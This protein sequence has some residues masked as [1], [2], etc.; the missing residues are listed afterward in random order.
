VGVTARKPSTS[1]E[2]NG[3]GLF[4]R[5]STG[6]VREIG[7]SSAF[8]VNAGAQSIG[9]A[10]AFFGLLLLLFPGVN[11]LLM[12]VIGGLLIAPLAWVYSQLAVTM[13]RSGGDYVFLSRVFHPVAGVTAGTLHLFIWWS[14]L[15]ALGAFWA[16]AF[17]PFTFGTLATVFHAPSL[18]SLASDVATRNGTFVATTTILVAAALVTLG[19]TKLAARV[20][21]W[22]VLA[23]VISIVLVLV[24]LFIHSAGD[25]Q[26]A[27]DHASGAIGT[28][29]R[30]VAEARAHGWGPGHTVSATL[31]ALPY[32]FLI[33][34]GYWYTA[35]VAGEVRRPG[36][37]QIV[38]T[39][40]T[41]AASVLLLALAWVGVE[42]AAGARF[43]EAA[44][45]LAG[46]APAVYAK[47]TP[48]G[49]SPHG[50]AVL[51]ADPVTRLVIA[52]GFLGW[53]LPVPI[54]FLMGMSRTLFALS[55]DR[56]LPRSVASVTSRRH[57]PAVALL[58][59]VV[60]SEAFLAL[61]VYEQGFAQAFRNANLLAL[62]LSTVACLAVI[63]LPFRRRGLYAAAPK[64]IRGAWLGVPPIVVIAAVGGV[65]CGAGVYLAL[66]KGQ[67]SGGY[68]AVS[69]A[70]LAAVVLAGPMLYLGSRYLRRREGIDIALAMRELPPE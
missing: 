33:F 66:T 2:G 15:A 64:L 20:A 52:V 60:I 57:T 63:A 27:V 42:R 13:P 14:G 68:T 18:A 38:S 22:S 58:I 47:L 61:I 29:G 3:G 16:R 69:V 67:Y 50:L 7:F 43:A 54:V 56:V 34:A 6:F 45:F 62:A 28:P 21:F 46:R 59:N 24:E 19:G 70:S 35:F 53:L 10:F 30:I 23:G 44:Y 41:I 9:G 51:L 5:R 25:L 40:V 55:F 49:V 32:A 31:A 1:V 12:L 4:V 26:R 37:T 36:R 17:L 11:I 48:V 8:G 39:L 65:F